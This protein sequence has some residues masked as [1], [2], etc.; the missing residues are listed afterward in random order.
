MSPWRG[1]IQYN[2]LSRQ[3]YQLCYI[4][5]PTWV[6]STPPISSIL[7]YFCCCRLLQYLK[8]SQNT[9]N[10]RIMALA[11]HKLCVLS[12]LTPDMLHKNTYSLAFSALSN[13]KIAT[14]IV[15]EKLLYIVFF[16][17]FGCYKF[18]I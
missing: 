6:Q 13:L 17:N 9:V 12:V 2:R 1:I 14:R 18:Y 11:S 7:R 3:S 5:F 8:C 15:R 16:F 10:A 4:H